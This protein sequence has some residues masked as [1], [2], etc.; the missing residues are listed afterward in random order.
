MP[1]QRRS[2]Q[3]TVIGFSLIG[4]HHQFLHIAPVAAALSRQAG[5]D[6][7]AYVNTQADKA[8]L[9]DLLTALGAGP[10]NITVLAMPSLAKRIARLRPGWRQAKVLRLL[11]WGRKMRQCDALITAERTST[12]FKSPVLSAIIGKC[13][14]LIHIPH[15]AGDRARGFE[16]RIARFDYVI[17]AG[18]KDRDRMI[19]EGLV[20]PQNCAIS[21]YIKLSALQRIKP[22]P[23]ELFSGDRPTI[24]Y[25]PHFNASLSSWHAGAQTV[26]DTIKADGSF[27]LIV[28]PH[29]RLFEGQNAEARAVWE[30][31]AVPGQVIIDL[32]SDRS[33]DMTYT[34]AADI[35]L[36]DVS[37]QVYEFLAHP[38]PCVFIN[39]H[40]ADWQDD[41]NYLIWHAGDVVRDPAEIGPALRAAIGKHPAFVTYQKQAVESAFGDVTEDAAANAARL[42][43][44]VIARSNA[45]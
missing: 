29:I 33:S 23:V 22:N 14:F 3:R 41:P 11:W 43:L 30:D 21:G 16:P 19:A 8:A 13:P 36:G 26:I 42:I 44:A 35:Y 37:S 27:N 7:Q 40:G 31:Q 39:S 6:V 18:P 32:G 4:G 34:R 1:Q 45:G 17:V 24:L 20:S 10:V 5:V 12:L 28:A 38:R 25:N 9:V 2:A 15:G